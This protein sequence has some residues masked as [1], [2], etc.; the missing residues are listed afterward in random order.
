MMRTNSESEPR[1]VVRWTIP[2][3]ESLDAAVKLYL[4]DDAYRTKAELVRDLLRRFLEERG[5]VLQRQE[6]A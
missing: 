3:P 1:R 4:Q 5:I 2:I 6:R